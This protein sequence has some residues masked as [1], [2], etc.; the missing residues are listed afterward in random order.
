MSQVLRLLRAKCQYCHHFR[1]P[2]Q[3]INRYCCKLRLIQH[4][5]L[6]EAVEL[7]SIRPKI[8]MPSV[9]PD[10]SDEFPHLAD[11]V[12]SSD[13]EDDLEILLHRRA[14]FVTDSI[15]KSKL[16]S[17]SLTWN[18]AKSEAISTE[19]RAIYKQ[20]LQDITKSRICARCKG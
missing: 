10:K 11:N 15:K 5:L 17:N 2:A 19:R 13:D 9:G 12:E 4:G 14:K 7:E 8:K 20:F 16:N 6:I 3:E 1:M 18:A